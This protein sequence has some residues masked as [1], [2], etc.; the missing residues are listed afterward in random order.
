MRLV[1]SDFTCVSNLITIKPHLPCINKRYSA[2]TIAPRTVTPHAK[3]C[4]LWWVL[5]FF[6]VTKLLFLFCFSRTKLMANLIEF[7]WEG[8]RF[9]EAKVTKKKKMDGC[10]K[11]STK[12]SFWSSYFSNDKFLVSLYLKYSILAQNFIFQSLV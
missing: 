4:G 11:I 8:E 5:C 10:F 12:S 2:F 6:S 1:R 7:C 9:N 3:Y